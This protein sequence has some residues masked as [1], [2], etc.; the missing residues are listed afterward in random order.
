LKLT[1]AQVEKITN[2]GEENITINLTEGQISAIKEA[3]GFKTIKN[4]VVL[5]STHIL[6]DNEVVLPLAIINGS[7]PNEEMHQVYKLE[8]QPSRIRDHL[9]KE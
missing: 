2:L 9:D 1:A 3:T 8:G 4:T 6:T 7:P 5:D